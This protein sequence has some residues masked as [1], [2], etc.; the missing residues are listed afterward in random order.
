MSARQQEGYNTQKSHIKNNLTAR[1]VVVKKAVI[2]KC[3]T[4]TS[5]ALKK[6]AGI[7]R[8]RIYSSSNSIKACCLIRIQLLAQLSKLLFFLYI[9]ILLQL[10][11]KKRII[12]FSNNTPLA[13]KLGQ[14]IVYK[15]FLL[16]RK[17]PINKV[18][19]I[20]KINVIVVITNRKRNI[21]LL[22]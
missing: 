11:C 9:V 3:F 12:S 22:S 15:Y 20:I 16:I 21:R 8:I 2:E 1:A 5:R 10:H 7:L 14:A 13:L 18:Q 6:K 17:Y 4:S 19:T